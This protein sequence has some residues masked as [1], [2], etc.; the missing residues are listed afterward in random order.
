MK[1]GWV[2]YIGCLGLALAIDTYISVN[3]ISARDFILVWLNE[4]FDQNSPFASEMFANAIFRTLLTIAG[5]LAIILPAFWIIGK[6]TILRFFSPRPI[7]VVYFILIFFYF[8]HN[9]ENK[10]EIVYAVLVFVSLIIVIAREHIF[11]FSQQWFCRSK[12]GLIMSAV[13]AHITFIL[14]HPL[15]FTEGRILGTLL[16]VNLWIYTV[17]HKNYWMGISLHMA[18]NFLFPESA[19]FHY[20]VFLHSC[21]LAYG[22]ETYPKFLTEPFEN[23]ASRPGVSRVFEAW[24]CFWSF[25]RELY[26]KQIARRRSI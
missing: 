8:Y 13:I 10:H 5:S 21:Y 25:P 14:L 23:L 2:I 1:Y 4:I 17:S 16:M 20:A 12:F 7:P 22:L 19:L 11:F 6:K 18:W 26:S 24:R 15:V 3:A 9:S